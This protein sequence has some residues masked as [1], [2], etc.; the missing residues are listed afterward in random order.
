M[1]GD[2]LDVRNIPVGTPVRGH[3]GSILGHVREV[4]PNYLLVHQEGQHGDH[5]IP[6]RSIKAFDGEVIDVSVTL[7]AV[8][9]VDD[10]ETAHRTEE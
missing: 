9:D 10:E 1:T 5:Q 3:D 4:H 8:T 7:G 6:V 2:P